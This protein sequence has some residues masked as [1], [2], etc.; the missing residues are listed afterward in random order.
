MPPTGG[1]GGNTALRDAGLLLKHLKRIAFAKDPEAA[2]VDEI[3]AYE[4]DMLDFAWSA[5]S[6]STQN[7]Q[8]I[9]AE[10]YFFPF[11]VRTF[12][13]TLNFLFGARDV[14]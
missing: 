9:C 1:E 12:M 14:D 8:I 5:V 6:R 2:M 7:A 11:M 4:K 3:P 10:G 13:K